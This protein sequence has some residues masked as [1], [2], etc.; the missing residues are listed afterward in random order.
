VITNELSS[1]R[2]SSTS[3]AAILN[4]DLSDSTCNIITCN[5]ANKA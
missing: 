1:N 3:V 4:Q 2:L 5:A